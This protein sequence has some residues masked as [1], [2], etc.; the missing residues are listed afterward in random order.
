MINAIKP[1]APAERARRPRN[2]LEIP[3]IILRTKNFLT[4]NA[5]AGVDNSGHFSVIYRNP[6]QENSVLAAADDLAILYNNGSE[7]STPSFLD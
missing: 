7:R 6:S 2:H 5:G 1:Y 3:F 4:I